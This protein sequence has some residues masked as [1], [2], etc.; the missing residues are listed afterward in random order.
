VTRSSAGGAGTAGGVRHEGRCV[1]WLAAHMLTETPLPEWASGRLV[2]GVGGQTGRP[3]DDVGGLTD[4]DGWVCVQAKKNLARSD[5]PDSDLAAALEQ[6]VV[7][8]VEGVPDRPPNQDELRPLD[9]QVD[10][11]LILTDDEAPMTIAEAMARL[12]DRLRA[13]PEAVPLV[14]AAT[15]A[16][17]RRALIT[18]RGHLERLW[19]ERHGATADESFVRSLLR[20]LAVRALDLRPDGGDLRALLPDFRD[21]LE[22][23]GKALGLWRELELISQRLAVERSWI[24]RADLVRELEAL[25]YHL[26]PIARLRRDVQRLQQVTA[27]N[28]NSPPSDLALT[29]P[30]GP[31][32]VSRAVS[33]VLDASDGNVA[34]TGDPGAGKS[35]L[36]HRFAA[37]HAGDVVY[38]THHQLRGTAGQ[39]RAEL[40]LDHDLYE[41]L[42][43]WTGSRPGLLLL[44][45][46]D[47]TRG[48]EASSWLPELGPAPTRIPMADRRQHP[49][50]RPSPR[51]SL[52]DDVPR[53]A[54]RPRPRRPGTLPGRPPCGR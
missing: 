46:I 7:I 22:D 39:T 40:N 17:E 42:T 11:V 24:R 10:R 13:W 27:A 34:V 53:E 32:E 14:E 12:V 1:A 38:L 8:R 35:V 28:L 5:A 52:A 37:G 51:P 4:A 2:V 9:P 29:T 47:Q 21:L 3:V 36:L 6:L 20:P 15:K 49:I 43:G 48:V 26:T 18:L 23:P 30:D 54:G 45:G 44:D 16:G 50:V 41:V 25:G 33:A 31:V 19:A